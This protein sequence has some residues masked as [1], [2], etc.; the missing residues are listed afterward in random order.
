MKIQKLLR[1]TPFLVMMA[2]LAGCGGSSS[3]GLNIGV[4]KMGYGVQWVKDLASS[5]TEKTGISVKVS[6]FD[7]QAGADALATAVD[8]GSQFDLVFTKRG[9]FESD[10]YTKK[11][12]KGYSPL[13]EDITESVYNYTNPG[14]SKTIGEKLS[15]DMKDYYGFDGHYYGVPWTSGFMG[16]ARNVTLWKGMGFTDDDIPNTT[17]ELMALCDKIYEKN[18]T[19]PGSLPVSGR[20]YPFIYSDR[21]EYYTSIVNV[22]TAQYEGRDT[23]NNYFMKGLGIGETE[24]N[25]N[26]YTFD[27]QTAALEVMDQ[28]LNGNEGKRQDPTTSVDFTTTQSYFYG[29]SAVF[30]ING[31]WLEN[32]SGGTEGQS[33]VD[34]IKMPV[35]SSIVKRMSIKNDAD[36]DKK[37]SQA[38]SYVDSHATDGADAPLS[39]SDMKI[40]RDARSYSYLGGGVDHQGFLLAYAKN[41]DNGTEFLRYMYSDEGLNSYRKTMGGLCLPATPC[42]EFSPLDTTVSTFKKSVIAALEENCLFYESRKAKL[43]CLGKVDLHFQNGTGG[44]SIVSMLKGS[45]DLGKLTPDDIM[46]TNYDYIKKNL[47]TIQ[48]NINRAK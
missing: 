30:T 41:K 26:F 19:Y 34:Y 45:A 22:W 1:L 25:E 17:D 42:T 3:S 5:F 12:V 47:S 33:E 36:A 39:E 40:V 32:E 35:V 4:V 11:S 24:P 38:I 37:L 18:Y 23:V 13:Y 28:L 27:G 48:D 46:T 31:S 16:V 14:E 2:P 29:G 8:N 43:F 7:G 10:I 44:R 20:V 15:S 21:A 6:E 9:T